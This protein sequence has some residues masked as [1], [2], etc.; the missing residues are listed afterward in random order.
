M[1]RLLLVSA[2]FISF[3][4]FSTGYL[5]AGSTWDDSSCYTQCNSL[6]GTELAGTGQSYN[7]NYS[8]AGNGKC[9][10][11]G[12]VF[13]PSMPSREIVKQRKKELNIQCNSLREQKSND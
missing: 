7:G 4:A 3:S 8:Y 1:Y 2:L 9:I 13:N 10:C 12:S 11:Y 6:S 5:Q